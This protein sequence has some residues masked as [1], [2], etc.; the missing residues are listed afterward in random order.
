MWEFQNSSGKEHGFE[1]KEI[2]IL[3][4]YDEVWEKI[5]SG[6]RYYRRKTQNISIT[7]LLTSKNLKK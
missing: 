3:F 4:T 5:L 6:Y 7:E 1:R 2:R